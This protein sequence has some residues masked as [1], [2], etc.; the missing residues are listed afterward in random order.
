VKGNVGPDLNLIHPGP[1]TNGPLTQ[2]QI[3][4]LIAFLNSR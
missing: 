2:T 3:A 4:D 1:F